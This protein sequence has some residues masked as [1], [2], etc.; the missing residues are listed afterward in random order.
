M[1]LVSVVADTP[2]VRLAG[3]RLTLL[4][5]S[6]CASESR[7]VPE[8]AWPEI[9]TPLDLSGSIVVPYP[10]PVTRIETAPPAPQN[11]SCAYLDGRWSFGGKDWQ[12]TAG[13]WVIPPNGCAFARPR[14]F[15]HEIAADRSELR[16]R[17]GRWVQS[18][19]LAA[20]CQAAIPCSASHANTPP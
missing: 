2:P 15:W 13:T 19:N 10:P 20:E 8:A 5:L 3:V 4:L 16:F 18:S 11:P 12:W 7:L 14:V 6:A 1:K 17:P 9:V